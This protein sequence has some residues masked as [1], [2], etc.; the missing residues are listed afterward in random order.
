MIKVLVVDDNKTNGEI[1]S[2]RLKKRGF[3]VKVEDEGQHAIDRLCKEK[4]DLIIMDLHMP[5][6]SGVET[7]SKIKSNPDIQAI[8][9]IS[10]TATIDEK[11]HQ[12]AIAAGSTAVLE[13]MGDISELMETIS[14]IFPDQ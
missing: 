13:K 9:I 2:R 8:P 3:L 1:L 12:E 6:M 5:E 14:H 10:F 4:Y 11:E 7:I